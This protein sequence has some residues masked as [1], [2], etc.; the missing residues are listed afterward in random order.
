M[1]LALRILLLFAT[2]TA[3]ALAAA[4]QPMIENIRFGVVREVSAGMFE[5]V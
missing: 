3:S 2:T 4:P 5:F 1:I